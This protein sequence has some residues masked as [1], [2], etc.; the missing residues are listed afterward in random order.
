MGHW[1][2]VFSTRIFITNNWWKQWKNKCKIYQLFSIWNHLLRGSSTLINVASLQPS[3]RPHPTKVKPPQH[4][5]HLFE[6]TESHHNQASIEIIQQ[7]GKSPKPPHVHLKP[8][9]ST[10]S[11]H[12]LNRT[13]HPKKHHQPTTT[14]PSKPHASAFRQRPHSRLKP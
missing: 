2:H 6:T 1:Y 5:F 4:I 3:K 13:A 11:T 14:T 9:L 8:Y 12:I 10:S 7:N